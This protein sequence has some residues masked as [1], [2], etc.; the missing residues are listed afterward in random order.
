MHFPQSCNVIYCYLHETPIN[1]V[2]LAIINLK[3]SQLAYYSCNVSPDGSSV[4]VGI[5]RLKDFSRRELKD[6]F[7]WTILVVGVG[8]EPSQLG[9]EAVVLLAG[10]G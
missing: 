5:V 9:G 4:P 7:D 10:T 3:P 1:T 6:L 8:V 2:L